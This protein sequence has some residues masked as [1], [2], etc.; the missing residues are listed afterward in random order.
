MFSDVQKI[1]LPHFYRTHLLDGAPNGQLRAEKR[2]AA[3]SYVWGVGS[4]SPVASC[5]DVAEGTA[6]RPP[7]FFNSSS[8]R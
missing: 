7:N 4:M 5:V 8:T 6:L 1:G 3:L 2:A